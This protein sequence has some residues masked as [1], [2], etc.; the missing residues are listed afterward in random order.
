MITVASWN[1][2]PPVNRTESVID[3][4]PAASPKVSGWTPASSMPGRDSSSSI[5]SSAPVTVRPPVA[6]P[7][8]WIVS[9]VSPSQNV[10][11][12]GVTTRVTLAVVSP[13]GMLMDGSV[14]DT[15]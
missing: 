13:D 3:C 9:F 15:V 1:V 11:S 10:S 5:S 7:F 6:L 14:P 2:A 12:L 8:T 4:V